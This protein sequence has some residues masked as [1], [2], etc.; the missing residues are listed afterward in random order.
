MPWGLTELQPQTRKVGD[1][2]LVS[3]WIPPGE[4]LWSQNKHSNSVRD[5]FLD[6]PLPTPVRS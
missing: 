6:F 2:G 3:R 1:W 5:S 4:E